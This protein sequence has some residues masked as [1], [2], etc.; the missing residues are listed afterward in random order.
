MESVH[1]NHPLPMP[2]FFT[3]MQIR[4]MLE[5]KFNIGERNCLN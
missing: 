3:G 5:K 4:F 1:S 2:V